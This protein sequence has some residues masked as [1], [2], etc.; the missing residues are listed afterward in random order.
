M[1]GN[2]DLLESVSRSFYL[3]LRALPGKLREPIG[4]AYLLARASDTIADT[5]EA[6]VDVRLKHLT[7]LRDGRVL[8]QEIF[9]S[10]PAESELLRRLN[11]A[12]V[13]LQQSPD[14]REIEWVLERIIRGQELDLL[15]PV[16]GSEEEVEEYTY[17]VA[18]CVGEFWTRLCFKHLSNFSLR[19]PAEME[20]LGVHFGKGLQLVNI[21]RDRLV[22]A[23]HGRCYL[24]GPTVPTWIIRARRYLNDASEYISA[25]RNIR[26]RY[27][28]I[29]PWHLGVKTLDSLE[30][31]P[32]HERVKVPR[33]QVRKTMLL[34]MAGACSNRFLARMRR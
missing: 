4:L 22:D 1:S 27:A 17:L 28:C 9:P 10:T 15:R 6:P 19:S 3:T 13:T 12:L 23:Q 31:H 25:I 20:R 24:S 33:S 2:P 7:A 21:L 14:R 29:L 5:P 30:Q 8:E 11:E 26:L 16:L 32:D 34:A 18:G